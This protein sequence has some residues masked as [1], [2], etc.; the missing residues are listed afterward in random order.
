MK[1]EF[2]GLG[3]KVLGTPIATIEITEDRELFAQQMALINEKCAQSASALTTQ[4]ACE[5]ADIIGYPVIIRAAYA[6]GGL[7][8]G[9]ADN[10]KEL[11]DLCTKAFATT[12][13]ILVEKSMKG[14]KEIEYEVVRDAYDNC[15]TV[16][17]MEN[18]D[19]LGI[20]TGDS[21]V[22]APSQ[23][24]SN[25]D[26]MMLRKTAINVIR[27]LGNLREYLIDIKVSLVNAIFSMR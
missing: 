5:S 13:Q 8:S 10:Q 7:G 27:H 4:S 16:C 9:F 14:W 25:D 26:F 19:P 18:F 1:S 2:E 15:I 6:L 11:I 24:L 17:N 12:T 22:V 23:T 3:V 20:H 21:I